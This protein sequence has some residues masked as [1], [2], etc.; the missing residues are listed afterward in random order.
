MDIY[1]SNISDKYVSLIEETAA[2]FYLA[3][4]KFFREEFN[5]LKNDLTYVDREETAYFWPGSNGDDWFE[6][7]DDLSPQEENS[8]QPLIDEGFELLGI[9]GSRVGLSFPSQ[10]YVVKLARYG[11]GNEWA[12]GRWA[13]RVE[14]QLDKKYPD[15][16]RILPI[17]G[18][19]IYGNV[20]IMPKLENMLIDEPPEKQNELLAEMHNHLEDN[21][22][23]IS[24]DSIDPDEVGWWNDELWASDYARPKD[25]HTPRGLP[26][27]VSPN[28]NK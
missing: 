12:D 11:W 13:N 5:G 26:H 4:A 21:V 20:I 28:I 17:M 24:I 8:I 27:F 7:Y 16:I 23:E 10:D 2:D 18:S 1:N 15:N 22:P 14:I 9:G 25:K 6:A 3:R 19:D